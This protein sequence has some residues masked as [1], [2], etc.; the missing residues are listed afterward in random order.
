MKAQKSNIVALVIALAA[1]FLVAAIGGIATASSVSTWYPTLN[2]PAWNPPAWLF[3]P[4]WT[5]LYLM[6]GI[7]SWLV[8]QK[9]VQNEAQVRR[10]LGWYGL[11]LGL[12]LFWSVIFFGLRQV[13]L[14]L[15]EIVALWSTLLITIV[16]FGRIRR[17]AA[18]LLLPYL[19]WTTF[20][21][22]LNATIW[23]LNRNI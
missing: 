19:L 20:A 12:N 4:V 14:A 17:D 8:W 2:K 18:G 10:A 23:W 6:M 11:Q 16:K 15:I 9:R 5:L 13:G 7:A 3:G 1:P 21:A 22:A